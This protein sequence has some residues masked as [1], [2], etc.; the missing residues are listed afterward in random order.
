MPMCQMASLQG[1]GLDLFVGG[2]GGGGGGKG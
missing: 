1:N 2:G